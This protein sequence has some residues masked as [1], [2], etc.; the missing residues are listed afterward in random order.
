MVN[1]ELKQEHITV[2]EELKKNK[3]SHNNLSTN[4][5]SALPKINF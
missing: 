4:A 5:W 1:R 3:Y 2:L